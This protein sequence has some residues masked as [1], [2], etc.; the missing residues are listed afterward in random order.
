MKRLL[1][2]AP[3]A[4]LGAGIWW[5]VTVKNA[6][7]EVRFTVA[8]TGPLVDTLMTNGKVEPV[9]YAAVRAERAGVLTKLLVEKGQT[10]AAGAVIAEIDSAEWRNATEAAEARVA[11]VQAELNVQQSGGR[12][13]DL[14]DIDGQ[15]AKLQLERQQAEAELTTVRRLIAKNAATK[16][17]AQVLEDRIAQIQQQ[18]S[19]LQSR[20]AVL[21]TPADRSV[22]E[23]RLREARTAVAAARDKQGQGILRAPMS[24]VVYQ[25]DP[26]VG[27]FLNPGDLVA[28]IGRV[29]EL[30]VKVFID[31]PELGRV[32]AGMAALITWDAMPAKQW[33]GRVATMPAQIVTMGTRQVGEVSV[34]IANVEKALPPGAN[35]NAAI[36]SREAAQ[37]VTIPK[38]S[39]RREGGEQ[40]VYVLVGTKVE[41]RGVKLG[42]TNITHAQVLEGVAAG[43]RVVLA[44]DVPIRAGQT[45][46]PVSEDAGR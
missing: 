18:R 20:R 31:E 32:A 42:V 41:W 38:E 46:T 6:P 29:D 12:A 8:K 26:R 33:E 43:D 30:L 25:V 34:R 1:W 37:A 11:Q 40:G 17:E 16:Q 23:A 13:S 3:L 9:A 10:V 4:L 14:A 22:L 28:N 27:S 5:A 39:L 44:T 15:L 19:A 2:L 21:F 24:G 35:I 36:R 45:V 7:P